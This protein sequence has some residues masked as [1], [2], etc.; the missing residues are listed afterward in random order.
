ME[1]HDIEK[2]PSH[3]LK[4]WNI[5]IES[6][7]GFEARGISRVPPHE[8]RPP[9]L[10]DDI[11]VALLWFSA[12]ISVNN[13]A[14]GLFGPLVFGLG[15][16]DSA[17]CAVFGGL[18]GSMS[19]AYMSI[20]GPQS[21]N[22]TMVVLRYF[23]GYWPAKI[24]TLL[25]IVLMVGYCTIDA[26]IS[27]Q[28][29]SAINGGSM[30]IVVGIIVVQIVSCIV[31]V[32]GMKIFQYYER[33]SWIP[34]V[35]I[36]FILIGSAAP[37]FDTSVQSTGSPSLIAANR[38]SFFSLCIYIPNSWG[39]AASDF[40]VYYPEKTSKLKIFSMTLTGLWLS[41]TLV[42]LLGIGFATGITSNAAWSDAYNTSIGALIV[43]GYAP[44]HSFG[45]FCAVIV[46][47]GV[48][49]NLIPGIYSAA[50][51][52]Q[53]LGRYGKAVPRWVW[54]CVLIIIVLVIALAGRQH[55]LA[56]IQNFVALMG[57]WIEFVVFIV[58]VEHL[59]FRRRKGFEFDWS[60]WEDKEY[61][62]I[63]IAA[64]VAFLIGW[65]G[66]ILGMFQVWY[67][68][69]I[70]AISGPADVGMWVGTAFTIIVYVP[71][72]WAELEYFG[73]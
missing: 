52:C 45:K 9:S 73:R 43:S 37:S 26:I 71:L 61:L 5:A 67:T 24:P 50:L 30:S 2:K 32:F 68:G 53:V 19:T 12:N 41:F 65:V 54:S 21:G 6:L 62:P 48:I 49:S 25:N 59:W 44:L 3:G 69:P 63:G 4:K 42:Y 1:S 33:F 64:L 13:L 27:G 22:R 14:V 17:M 15:F 8:R 70:A 72:R 23:M 16:V 35:L 11:S 20:W 55:L 34:Q 36:L 29:L 57:Y 39:A 7:S 40:Y 60:K 56:I 66:A 31:A 58:L 10:W 46:A 51:G 38:L 18:L 47:L 28:M